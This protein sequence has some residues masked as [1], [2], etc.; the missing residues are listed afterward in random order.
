MAA[1]VSEIQWI[2]VTQEKLGQFFRRPKLAEK[3]LKK[4]PVRYIRDI[5]VSTLK[6]TGFPQGLFNDE[7]LTADGK[8]VKKWT[9]GQKVGV[10]RRIHACAEAAIG[11][12]I[13]FTAEKA[14]GGLEPENTNAV[15][16][17]IADGANL[18]KAGQISMAD[19]LERVG[20]SG[21]GGELGENT[22]EEASKEASEANTKQRAVE[23]E[24]AQAMRA[25]KLEKLKALKQ[26]KR[27]E[28]VERAR[29]EASK[30]A[31][32]AKVQ[33][34]MNE[35]ATSVIPKLGMKQDQSLRVEMPES[36]EDAIAES[37]NL[38]GSLIKKPPALPKYLSRPPVRY[39]HDVVTNLINAT[40]VFQ[41]SFSE[42]ELDQKAFKAADKKTK[43]IFVKKVLKLTSAAIGQNLDVDLRDVMMGKEPIKTNMMLQAIAKIAMAETSAPTSKSSKRSEPP[44][45]T[46]KARKPEPPADKPTSRRSRRKSVPSTE[47]ADLR[48]MALKAAESPVGVTMPKLDI[49]NISSKPADEATSAYHAAAKAEAEEAEREL[50]SARPTTARPMTARRAPPKVKSHLVEEKSKVIADNNAESTGLITEDNMGEDM[51]EDEDND[52]E[53]DVIAE[54]MHVQE[55]PDASE[56]HGKLVTDILKFQNKHEIKRKM[57]DNEG[58]I[59][60]NDGS[61][62]QFRFG[63][64]KKKGPQASNV[65]SEE[66]IVFVR[67]KIQQLCQSATPLG[68]CIDYVFEDMER[69]NKEL[70]QWNKHYQH[71]CQVQQRA[72]KETHE[73]L[74]PLLE[75]LKKLGEDIQKEKGQAIK[76]QAQILQNE[77]IIGSHLK[78]QSG[79]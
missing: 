70:A 6:A 52:Q 45:T 42:E 21:W 56:A 66:Q 30:A 36:L 29:Q 9:R 2:K 1:E 63:R 60:T 62:S 43:A 32:E 3:L 23:E 25:A 50:R 19:V 5:L 12:R 79:M 44:S 15:L 18:L 64:L 7:V 67:E 11:E 75:E 37:Q 38:L 76:L 27:E 71:E 34:K 22:R 54:N 47:V 10:L 78:A 55:G 69:M 13:H 77:K 59:K 8:A 49:G 4:P 72:E 31:S 61:G 39:I 40:G 26:K 20:D 73:Q 41:G 48:T 74:D 35:Q 65:Y 33:A 28:K 58:E 46:R 53:C 24:R 16:Q 68:K 14:A 17:G 57:D 51:D